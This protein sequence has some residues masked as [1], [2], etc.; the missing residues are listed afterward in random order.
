MSTAGPLLLA[1]YLMHIVIISFMKINK[2]L[3]TT[4]TNNNSTSLFVS[5]CC[6]WLNNNSE[7]RLTTGQTEDLKEN[8]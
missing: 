5:L 3:G 4:T 7:K 8:K 6:D 1:G 2:D